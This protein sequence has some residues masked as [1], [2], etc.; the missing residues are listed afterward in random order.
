MIT[1]TGSSV[2]SLSNST[3]LAT[4]GFSYLNGTS[5]LS[6]N[7]TDN[8]GHD[9]EFINAAGNP[10]T[11]TPT[12]AFYIDGY[13]SPAVI[14]GSVSGGTTITYGQ[15]TGPLTLS[16]YAGNIYG[17]QKQYNGG[18]Y[19]GISGTAG[20]TSYSE[21]PDYTGTWE[22]RAV[23]QNGACALEYSTPAT[24]IVNSPPGTPKTW[25]GSTGDDW[26]TPTNWS[27][28]GVPVITDDVIMSAH[29]TYMPVVRNQGLGCNNLTISP[30]G[31]VTIMPGINLTINGEIIIQ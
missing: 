31:I 6:F 26:I 28:P 16:G 18:G 22:Y 27:P 23:L 21:Y 13:V 7:N 9:C 10:M 3:T 19:S 11:D 17:W 29:P 12:S 24:V 2:Q 8:G 5:A 15:S 20:F 1:W 14:G 25:I 30:N 4:L